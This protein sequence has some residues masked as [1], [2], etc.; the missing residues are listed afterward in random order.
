MTVREFYEGLNEE[1]R[2]NPLCTYDENLD[3]YEV[4]EKWV[5]QVPGPWLGRNSGLTDVVVV[6]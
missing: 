6:Y 2:D 3:I 4:E 5:T 1:Q